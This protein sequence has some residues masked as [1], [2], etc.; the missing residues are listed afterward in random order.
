MRLNF[1]SPKKI[2]QIPIQD[3]I[4]MIVKSVDWLIFFS[5]RTC[6]EKIRIINFIKKIRKGGE[7]GEGSGKLGG[8]RGRAP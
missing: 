2:S 8:G 5:N 7:G 4:L 6:S 3:L 1:T